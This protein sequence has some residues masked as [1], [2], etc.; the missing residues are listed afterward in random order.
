MTIYSSEN[1]MAKHSYFHDNQNPIHVEVFM[2][3][4]SISLPMVATSLSRFFKTGKG[5]YGEGDKFLGIKVPQIH[6]IVKQ[7]RNKISISDIDALTLSEWH[8]VRLAGFLFLEDKFNQACKT[9][10]IISQEQI[11]ETYL[12]HI[13][14]GNNWDLVDLVC[15]KILGKWI[16]I[17]PEQ[18]KILYS[19]ANSENL[20]CQRAAIVSTLSLVRNN[21]FEHTLKI[22]EL[23]L[24]HHHDLINKAVGWLLRECGKKRTDILEDFLQKHAPSMPRVTLRYA[25]ERMPI[26]QR[27]YYMSI[28]KK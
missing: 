25:I 15:H 21:N 22:A 6:A 17:R 5:E 18:N 12:N 19:L 27:K 10:D 28:Q 23:L 13:P 4:Q 26:E 8:E 14:R 3:L 16:I 2:T 1:D 9:N 20:W 7:Y 24:N 11:V